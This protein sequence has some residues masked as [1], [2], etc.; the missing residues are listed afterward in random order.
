MYY[1][2]LPLI[3]WIVAFF[4]YWAYLTRSLV[5]NIL[6]EDFVIA[7]KA[8]GLPS[9]LIT[10]RYI[11]KPISPALIATTAL[12]IVFAIQGAIVTETVFNWPGLGRLYFEAIMMADAPVIIQLTVFYAY[13]LVITVLILD[14]VYAIIDPRIR[15]GI[16]V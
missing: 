6:E 12:N 14:I 1:L 2:A 5:V 11:L 13:L 10:T 3:T 7:A 16:E 4:G 9:N 15:T 8:R